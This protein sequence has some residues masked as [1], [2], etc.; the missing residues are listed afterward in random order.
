M[1]HA[2]QDA[3]SRDTGQAQERHPVPAE[4]L[5]VL[6]AAGGHIGVGL[7]I[8][9]CPPPVLDEREVE[10][11]LQHPSVVEPVHDREFAVYAL[12]CACALE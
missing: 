11:A 2:E 9:N 7:E 12:R 5:L 6:T 8:D 1:L 10:H 3:V 4:L